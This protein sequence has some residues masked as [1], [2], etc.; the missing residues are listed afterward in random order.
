MSVRECSTASGT[1]LGP[2]AGACLHQRGA[3]LIEML[4]AV[5]V[6]SIG[7]LGVATLQTVGLR[8]NHE[9]YLRSQ[10]TLLAH[11]II[12]RMR[13]NREAALNGSYVGTGFGD[14]L[15]S[16]CEPITPSGGLAQRD[17][18]EWKQALTCTLPAGDGAIARNGSVFTVQVRWREG[19]DDAA[20]RVFATEV[21]L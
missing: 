14:A 15:P 5:L 8:F 20:D 19:R 21:E 2:E 17:V 1:G 6:L 3:T 11:D 4:I 10:A 9:A 18:Q 7:L 16:A 13:A 12:D